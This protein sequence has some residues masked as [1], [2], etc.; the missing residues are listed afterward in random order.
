MD[1]GLPLR[2]ILPLTEIEP[3]GTRNGHFCPPDK[4]WARSDSVKNRE[5]KGRSEL[6]K[7]Y[8]ESVPRAATTV[9]LA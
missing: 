6:F 5:K 3:R 7:R 2:Q 9:I 4:Q 1:F 8:P